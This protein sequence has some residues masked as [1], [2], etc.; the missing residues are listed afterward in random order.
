MKGGGK[1]MEQMKVSSIVGAYPDSFVVAQ[2]VERSVSGTVELAN[3]LGVCP[4]KQEAFTQQAIYTLAGVKTFIIPTFEETEGAIHIE[5]AGD[6]YKSEPLLTPAE[7]A[8]IFR[9]YYDL[10][11]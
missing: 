8:M 1:I 11:D 5:F 4:T 6:E 3:V 10:P 9:Q 7:S 2:A